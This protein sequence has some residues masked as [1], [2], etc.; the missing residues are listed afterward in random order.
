MTGRHRRQAAH[1]SIRVQHG[2]HPLGIIDAQTHVEH[3]MADESVRAHG[4]SGRY[5]ALCG[6]QVLAAS[7][8]TPDR[9]R[10][11]MCATRSAL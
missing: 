6:V 2:P 9:G 8:A 10:C 3:L 4:D 1:A 7:L 11:P 5:L